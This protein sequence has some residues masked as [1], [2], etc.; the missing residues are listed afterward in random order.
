MEGGRYF[1]YEHP[2]SA[3]S[4]DNPS[5]VK[6]MNT[7]GVMKTELDQCEFGL[8]SKDEQ[9]EAPAKKSRVAGQPAS[10]LP[11]RQPSETAAAAV[12]RRLLLREERQGLHETVLKTTIHATEPSCKRRC[13]IN[14]TLHPHLLLAPR[15]SQLQ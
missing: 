7:E 2:K 4:W 3:A 13:P 10:N 15:S 5:I 11:G 14:A 9:G 8:V 1:V 12:A 6:L